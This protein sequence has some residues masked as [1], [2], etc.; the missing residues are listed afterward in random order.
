MLGAETGN[1]IPDCVSVCEKVMAAPPLQE[2]RVRLPSMAPQA[3][4]TI[5]SGDIEFLPELVFTYNC[6]PHST[7][8]YLPSFLVFGRVPGTPGTS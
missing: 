1:L 3:M 6:S 7:T 2:S 8:G 5:S 4:S